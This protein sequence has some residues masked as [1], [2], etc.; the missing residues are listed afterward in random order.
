MVLK[1]QNKTLRDT[2]PVLTK[3]QF[4]E[5]P[6]LTVKD[7]ADRSQL[8]SQ[9]I[10]SKIRKGKIKAFLFMGRIVIPL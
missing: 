3:N 2:L 4:H 5:K 7:Y 6:Y 9:A 8:T 1:Q 10:L